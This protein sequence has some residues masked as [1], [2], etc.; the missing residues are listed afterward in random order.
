M[1]LGRRSARGRRQWTLRTPVT[2]WTSVHWKPAG[3][4]QKRSLVRQSESSR[5]WL[6]VVE[7][8]QELT[9]SHLRLLVASYKTTRRHITADINLNSD[10]DVDSPM[11]FTVSRCK[12]WSDTVDITTCSDYRSV[13]SNCRKTD[14][15]ELKWMW[16]GR[17]RWSKVAPKLN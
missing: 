8:S 11:G 2:R 9:A 1:T 14:T 13:A 16:K 12:P 4:W 3:W 5:I 17:L 10:S 7:V 15:N 6:I